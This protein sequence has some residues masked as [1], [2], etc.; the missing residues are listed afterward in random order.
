MKTF[1]NIGIL[2]IACGA[3]MAINGKIGGMTLLKDG[4]GIGFKFFWR[5][6]PMII[7]FTI[8]A[9]Q[10]EAFY[11]KHPDAIRSATTGNA[12]IIKAALAGALI[13]GGTSAGPILKSEWS[14]GGNKFAIIAFIIA[15]S[16][17]N[18]NMLLFRLPFF[19]EKITLCIY[20][21]GIAIVSVVVT[22]MVLIHHF[23]G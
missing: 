23:K 11:S 14:N 12:G 17:I 22:I 3:L 20:G 16:L 6:L 4:L 13:P 8:L 15:M 10:I 5:I 2:I 7:V 18:W 21:I 19:G 9:G 1:L